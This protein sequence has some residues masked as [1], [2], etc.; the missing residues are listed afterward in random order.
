MFLFNH[1]L[2][3][4]LLFRAR[5]KKVTTSY[6]FSL[7]QAQKK[8]A[9]PILLPPKRSVPS[10]RNQINPSVKGA[11]APTLLRATTSCAFAPWGGPLDF[12]GGNVLSVEPV[13]KYDFAVPYR[14][15]N[16][17]QIYQYQCQ[18]PIKIIE[19]SSADYGILY[20]AD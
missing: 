6:C 17:Q 7:A 9:I 18:N 3:F 4:I 8:V 19:Q 12:Q 11:T 1:V 5:A 2:K 16:K 14:Y 13:N 10:A 20:L 15:T